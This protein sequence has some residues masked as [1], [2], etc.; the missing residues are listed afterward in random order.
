M[1]L[2]AP[3]VWRRIYLECHTL[4]Q[5]AVGALVGSC[6]GTL[7][8]LLYSHV[9]AFCIHGA[10]SAPKQVYSARIE[11]AWATGPW[12]KTRQPCGGPLVPSKR[13]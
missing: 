2:D 7:W 5:V 11:W 1:S 6:T 3:H 13:I 4:K 8:Y 12:V 9:S 10:S